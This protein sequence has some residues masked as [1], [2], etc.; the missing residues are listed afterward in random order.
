MT[1][2]VDASAV[3]HAVLRRTP[4]ARALRQRLAGGTCHAPHLHDAELGNIVRRYV[5]RGEL[6][7]AQAPSQ[8]LGGLA[9]IDV[10]HALSDGLALAAWDLRDTVTFYD[11]TYVA[12]A[13]SLGVTLLTADARLARAPG[14][15][16]EVELVAA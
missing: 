13:Y 15:P 6:D 3:A 12:L 16:C 7:P 1:L 11:A 2:V 8:L 10:R 9:L 4:D 14:L 5:L